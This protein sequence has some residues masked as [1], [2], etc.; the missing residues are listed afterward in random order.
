MSES[1]AGGGAIFISAT[2]MNFSYG[3]GVEI[4]ADGIDGG[5]GGSIWISAAVIDWGYVTLLFPRIKFRFSNFRPLPLPPPP[6]S[7][8]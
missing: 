7:I 5:A 3:L 4:S 6:P 2:L 1:S 8:C